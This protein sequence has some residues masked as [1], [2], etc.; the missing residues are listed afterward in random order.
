VLGGFPPRGFH[1]ERVNAWPIISLPPF[2]SVECI[3]LHPAAN[4]WVRTGIDKKPSHLERAISRDLSQSRVTDPEFVSGV[5]VRSGFDQVSRQLEVLLLRCPVQ[6]CHPQA[7]EGVN[8][9][10]FREEML[11]Q[12]EISVLS[13]EVEPLMLEPFIVTH[14]DRYLLQGYLQPCLL[15][16]SS[17]ASEPERWGV[18]VEKM[19]I[20][21]RGSERLLLSISAIAVAQASATIA[22]V[23]IHRRIVIRGNRMVKASCQF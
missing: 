14:R 23:I 10:T 16:H 9:R 13:G 8:V 20:I 5:D 19:S 2:G 21:Q 15:A 3:Q 12:R 7:V 6:G 1:K 17:Y 4:R 11:D 22:T 18:S